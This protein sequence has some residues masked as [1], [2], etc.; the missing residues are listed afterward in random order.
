M[1]PTFALQTTTFTLTT[2]TRTRTY[3]AG[4]P[5]LHWGM[6]AQSPSPPANIEA[7]IPA[8]SAPPLFRGMWAAPSRLT[9]E[10]GM[11]KHEGGPRKWEAHSVC[12]EIRATM[13]VVACFHHLSSHP[14]WGNLTTRTKWQC[15]TT[16]TPETPMTPKTTTTS[17]PLFYLPRIQTRAAG[18]FFNGFNAASTTST[19]LASKCELEVDLSGVSTCL[20]PPPPPS[21]PN[22]SQRWTFLA[23]Q[24][25]WHHHHLPCIQMRAGGRLFSGFKAAAIA[26]TSLALNASQRWIV[27]AFWCHHL[28]RGVFFP[29][30]QRRRG[31][32][33]PTHRRVRMFS[34]PFGAPE[35]ARNF[36]A[37]FA[38][39]QWGVASLQRR[40]QGGMLPFLY[41]SGAFTYI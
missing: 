8:A 3:P 31:G 35:A 14:H 36:I 40:R 17:P 38:T 41:P 39:P 27:L 26:S 28:P 29:R 2:P 12:H 9:E 34:L 37:L 22:A 20:A 15:E 30:H 1:P 10:L 33:K 5:P 6:W 18:G 4:A 23:F 32:V 21:H 7:W 13:F 16:M 11:E 25:V 19:T 24:H